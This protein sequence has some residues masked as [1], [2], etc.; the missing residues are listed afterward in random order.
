MIRGTRYDIKGPVETDEEG[1]IQLYEV[2][3]GMRG[4]IVAKFKPR[5]NPQDGESKSKLIRLFGG[6]RKTKKLSL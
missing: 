2:I 5:A 4:G 1:F 3:H 6:N